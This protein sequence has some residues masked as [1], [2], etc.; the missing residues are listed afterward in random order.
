MAIAKYKKYDLLNKIAAILDQYEPNKMLCAHEIANEIKERYPETFK[1]IGKPVGGTG[2]TQDTLTR[3]IALLLYQTRKTDP[4]HN[5][6]F[7]IR[8]FGLSGVSMIAFKDGERQK[9]NPYYG[10]AL[11]ALRR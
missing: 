3:Y 7:I 5:E 9:M 1:A 10:I 4:E 11:F 2:G 6:R 8:E